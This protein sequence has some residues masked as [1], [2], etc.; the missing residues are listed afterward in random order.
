MALY[1]AKW[2]IPLIAALVGIFR[3]LDWLCHRFPQTMYVILTII[4]VIVRG[5][6]WEGASEMRACSVH[7]HNFLRAEPPVSIEGERRRQRV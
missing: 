2:P 6:R 1:Y 4:R 5:G 7:S 3:G